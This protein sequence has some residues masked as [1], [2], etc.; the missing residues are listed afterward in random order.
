MQVK[1]LLQCILQK[2][3]LKIWSKVLS[4]DIVN[5]FSAIFC[6]EIWCKKVSYNLMQNTIQKFSQKLWLKIRPKFGSYN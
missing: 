1:Y 2:F 3:S 6:I 4:R 5:K